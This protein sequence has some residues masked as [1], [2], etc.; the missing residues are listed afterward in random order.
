LLDAALVG[1]WLEVVLKPRF[2]N[3]FKARLTGAAVS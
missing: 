1:L 3:H 2:V